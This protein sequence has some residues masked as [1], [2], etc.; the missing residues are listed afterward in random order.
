[1]VSLKTIKFL[2]GERNLL[3]VISVFLNYL[4][5]EEK[6]VVIRVQNY[7]AGTFCTRLVGRYFNAPIFSLSDDL[8][9]QSIKNSKL[10][11]KYSMAAGL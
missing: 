7:I 11:K 6:I 1:M 2:H 5:R 4:N 3:E 9:F 10:Y 8:N